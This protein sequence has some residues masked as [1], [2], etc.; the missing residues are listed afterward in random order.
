MKISTINGKEQNSKF[1]FSVDSAGDMN[2]DGYDDIIIGAPE[3]GKSYVYYGG[4]GGVD[5]GMI[6]LDSS[7]DFQSGTLDNVLIGDGDI[8]LEVDFTSNI[9]SNG[10]FDDGWNN[11]IFTNNFEGSSDARRNDQNN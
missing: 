4:E 7:E 1:G 3:S 6:K 9:I 10:W 2:G 11:W 8:Q 5:Y